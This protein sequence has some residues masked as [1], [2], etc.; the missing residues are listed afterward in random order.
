MICPLSHEYIVEILLPNLLK[1]A[2]EEH[3]LFNPDEET[4]NIIRCCVGASFT[5]GV[6]YDQTDKAKRPRERLNEAF[7]IVGDKK[8]KE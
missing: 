5:L 4:K 3:G 6:A 1:I 7:K 8:L 2:E